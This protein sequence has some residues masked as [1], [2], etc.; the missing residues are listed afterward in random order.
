MQPVCAATLD[1]LDV[2]EIAELQ[3]ATSFPGVK[4]ILYFVKH[5]T[6]QSPGNRCT[7]SLPIVRNA[8]PSTQELLSGGR[9]VW[10]WR[11][12]GRV[13]IG[14]LL[15]WLAVPDSHRLWAFAVCHLASAEAVDLLEHHQVVRGC[16]L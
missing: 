8:I 9:N 10:T 16:V 12:S 15:W 11:E 3:C 6:Q 5:A 13:S 1:V 4:H 7:L 2:D 14:L